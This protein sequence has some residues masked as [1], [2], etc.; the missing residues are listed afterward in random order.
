MMLATSL[1][2]WFYRHFG[3]NKYGKKLYHIALWTYQ[4]MIFGYHK[5]Y[6]KKS[7]NQYKTRLYYF[8]K[9]NNF[10]D[11]LNIDLLKYFKSDY[12]KAPIDEANLICIGS[13][14]DELLLTESR[15]LKYSKP[16]NIFGTG[17]M[18]CQED[19]NESFNRPVN[20]FALRGKLSLERCKVLL[21]S[22]LEDVVLG[23]PGLLIKRMFPE[24][25]KQHFHDVGIICHLKDKDSSYITKIQTKKKKIIF[26]DITLPT[27]EFVSKV[28]QCGFILS[29]ALHGL[30][31]ADALG[32]P[33]KWIILSGN[34]EGRG[35]KFKDY[36]SVFKSRKSSEPVDLRRTAIFDE[37]IDR[38]IDEYTDVREQVDDIC[39]N[40]EN[41]F[42]RLRKVC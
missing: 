15:T 33:N 29:S 20:I 36:Y 5:K 39:N 42:E 27:H 21:N 4:H 38:F 13:I 35:Y 19:S 16:I 30:I 9:I 40:L 17:F 1:F 24:L 18:M 37:D 26:I 6:R 14:L 23:D 10:G 32:I 11:C 31:C 34:V 3:K 8:A 41:A 12:S 28:A 2:E 22:K 7:N 25:I